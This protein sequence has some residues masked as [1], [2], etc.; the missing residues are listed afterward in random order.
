MSRADQPCIRFCN[1]KNIPLKDPDGRGNSIYRIINSDKK[2]VAIHTI[3]G[4][5]VQEGERC[6]Y[7]VVVNDILKAFYVELKGHDINKAMKQV[8]STFHLYKDKNK[9]YL[10][11]GRIVPTK[12]N[13]TNN[14][15]NS[16]DKLR[17]IFFDEN[18][19][20]GTLGGL[21]LID[22]LDYKNNEYREE[23]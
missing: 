2:E 1:D 6:D 14:W 12:V 21:K 8:I 17:A 20:N 9:S 23:I 19:R 7:L 22:M 10:Q 3:D 11:L 4:C 15:K 16:A 13:N 5:L 18:K